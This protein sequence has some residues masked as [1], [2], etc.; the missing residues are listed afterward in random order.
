[1][2]NEELEVT[3]S[4]AIDTQKII[5]DP[6]SKE[7]NEDKSSELAYNVRALCATSEQ[8]MKSLNESAASVH[9]LIEELQNRI[10]QQEAILTKLNTEAKV[11]SIIPDKL[12]NRINELVPNIAKEVETIYS[13]KNELIEQ[14]YTVLHESIN[15][16]IQDTF[17]NG[18]ILATRSKGEFLRNF[19]IASI[20]VT[21]ISTLTS[22][23]MITQFPRYVEIKGANDIAVY[24]SKVQLWGGTVKSDVAKDERT[25]N[26]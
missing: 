24:D 12:Q 18:N 23:A 13:S 2:S 6:I 19:A 14:K 8:T 22:Y 3:Q 11:L 1:M 7:S 9:R 21:I 25:K 16:T 5:D 4:N 15:K 20:L 17:D 26:K 10:N